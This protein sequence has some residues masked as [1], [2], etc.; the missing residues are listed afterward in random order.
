MSRRLIPDGLADQREDEWLG[1]ALDRE[2]R[3]YVADLEEPAY[4][5]RRVLAWLPALPVVK[6]I[7]IHA[8]GLRTVQ[9]A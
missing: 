1:D 4:G 7:V 8:P 9:S 5:R 6:R 2:R 3:L